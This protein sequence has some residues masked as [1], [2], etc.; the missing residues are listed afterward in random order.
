PAAPTKSARRA[1]RR[2]ERQSRPQPPVVSERIK[3]RLAAGPVIGGEPVG[4][5]GTWRLPLGWARRDD[6]AVWHRPHPERPDQVMCELP[7]PLTASVYQHRVT[8][9]PDCPDCDAVHAQALKELRERDRQLPPQPRQATTRQ[10]PR[11]QI[12]R[13][14]LPT[15]GRDR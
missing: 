10:P 3:E 8:N 12:V 11:A 7:L 9:D 13:G 5:A 15:L 6:Q 1:S 4:T 2:R 14:G